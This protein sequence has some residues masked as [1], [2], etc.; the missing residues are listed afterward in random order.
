MSSENTFNSF[1]LNLLS[2]C[3]LNP[4]DWKFFGENDNHLKVVHKITGKKMTVD[5]HRGKINSERSENI[6]H[7]TV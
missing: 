2:D 4:R 7:T 3:C 1:Q 5:K 6:E